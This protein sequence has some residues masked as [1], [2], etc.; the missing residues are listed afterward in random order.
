VAWADQQNPQVPAQQQ[1]PEAP[2]P[3]VPNPDAQDDNGGHR[4]AQ[5][6]PP[7]L[8]GDDPDEDPED[9][10]DGTSLSS[11][12][13]DLS[14]FFPDG[15]DNKGDEPTENEDL[16]EQGET[17]DGSTIYEVL[18]FEMLQGFDLTR[19]QALVIIDNGVTLPNVFARLFTQMALTEL[20]TGEPL[21][22][23]RILV[24]DRVGM[25]HQ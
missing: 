5:M 25:F 4:V 12:L 7:N 20:F 11:E 19:E 1:Q 21:D 2:N 13:S 6:P 15:G 9:S 16:V 24:M 18:F 14:T 22:M 17:D 10:D 23:L 8:G 3:G